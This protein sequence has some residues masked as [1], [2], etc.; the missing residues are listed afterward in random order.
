MSPTAPRQ[1]A[2]SKKRRVLVVED[3]AIVRDALRSLL[4]NCSDL[5]VAGEAA[6]GLEAVRQV[7]RLKPD[8]VLMDLSMPRSSGVEAIREIT[9]R[10]PGTRTLALTMC[11]DEES[12]LAAMR[13]GAGG[14]VLKEASCPELI[15]AMRQVIA[16]RAYLSPL[17]PQALL[18]GWR[19]DGAGGEGRGSLD[20]LTRRE[21][22]VLA[23]VAGGGT[24]R[25]IGESLGISPRTVDRHRT[26][27][28]EKLDLHSTSALTRYA[29]KQGLVS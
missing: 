2:T 14:Y 16:G 27:V 4:A 19:A 20:A 21:R 13:A 8:L 29:V 3:H 12:F 17:L 18:D 5:E 1:P 10:F 24:S 23:L 28:M 9:R 25:M 7:E 22:Q 15:A 11:K 26:T 6:D